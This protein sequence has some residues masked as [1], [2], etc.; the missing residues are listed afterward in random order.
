MRYLKLLEMYR[1]GEPVRVVYVDIAK[2]SYVAPTQVFVSEDGGK[3]IECAHIGIIGVS[4]YEDTYQIT[5]KG[6]AVEILTA[7]GAEVVTP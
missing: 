1:D 2:I 6:D 5:V 4:E 7:M 3:R